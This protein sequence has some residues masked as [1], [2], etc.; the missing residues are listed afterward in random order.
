MFKAI[1]TSDVDLVILD[2]MLP[3]EDGFSL[4]RRLRQKARIPSSW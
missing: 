1:E 3:G 2:V 4:C